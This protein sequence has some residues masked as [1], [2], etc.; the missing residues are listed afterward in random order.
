MRSS[1]TMRSS[2]AR[3]AGLS[4]REARQR[5]ARRCS[6]RPKHRRSASLRRAE[7]ALVHVRKAERRSR[8]TAP[9]S[10][11]G[12]APRRGMWRRA[13]RSAARDRSPAARSRARDGRA[14]AARRPQTDARP[15][16][17][18]PGRS[19][20]PSSYRATTSRRATRA[21]LPSARSPP[22]AVPWETL[23]RPRGPERERGPRRATAFPTRLQTRQGPSYPGTSRTR[24]RSRLPDRGGSRARGRPHRCDVARATFVRPPGRNRRWCRRARR[25]WR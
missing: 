14:Q 1:R 16:G 12:P 24:T 19:P 18:M 11:W 22:G 15:P 21:L 5:R 2:V 6:P 25:R 7:P 17:R 13:P 9:A 20:T 23:S 8:E 10:A 4:S 3:A